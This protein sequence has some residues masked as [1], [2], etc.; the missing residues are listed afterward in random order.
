[1]VR[2]VESAAAIMLF[3]HTLLLKQSQRCTPFCQKSYNRK[4]LSDAVF[5]VFWNLVPLPQEMA[6]VGRFVFKLAHEDA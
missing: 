1:M 5:N 6:L 4:H 2:L 3:A